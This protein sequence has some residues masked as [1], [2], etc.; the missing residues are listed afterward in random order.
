MGWAFVVAL[1]AILINLVFALFS[2]KEF[3]HLITPKKLA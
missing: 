1:I 2:N 3:Q